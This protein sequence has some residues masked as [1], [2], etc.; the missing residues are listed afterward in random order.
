M[1]IGAGESLLP[2]SDRDG[3]RAASRVLKS[4]SQSDRRQRVR[5]ARSNTSLHFKPKLILGIYHAE[6]E[7]VLASV[8]STRVSSS[9]AGTSINE[10]CSRRR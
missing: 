2:K 9:A 8:Y 1:F 3:L 4:S 5:M 7:K 6:A 10:S